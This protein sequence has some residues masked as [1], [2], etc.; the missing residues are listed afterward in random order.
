M[1]PTRGS[2]FAMLLA[3]ATACSNDVSPR[4]DAGS[5]AGRA[6]ND[7]ASLPDL[8][9]PSDVLGPVETGHVD[10][11]VETAPPPTGGCQAQAPTTCPTP[12]V[13]YADIAPIVE[14]RC[15]VCHN[16]TSGNWP[17]TTHRHVADWQDTIRAAMLACAMPPPESEM[18]MPVE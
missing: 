4:A 18:P 13:R 3:L 14:R 7:A 6:V 11:A 12:A 17:L 8:P 15:V 1:A 2:H 5:D 9:P 16:G 10:L